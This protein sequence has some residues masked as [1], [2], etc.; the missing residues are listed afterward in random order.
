M[1]PDDVRNLTKD[2]VVIL[3]GQQCLLH[4]CKNKI[5]LLSNL[6]NYEGN[7]CTD[8]PRYRSQYNY[9]FWL[10]DKDGGR[11]D[12]RFNKICQQL[13]FGSLGEL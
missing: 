8:F 7:T 3:K 2:T 4:L 12:A 13:T 11:R 10:I 6:V 9:S 5:Y 1:R